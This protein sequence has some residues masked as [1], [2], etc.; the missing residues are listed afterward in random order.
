M[1]Y[2]YD[3]LNKLRSKFIREKK[4]FSSSVSG[5][6]WLSLNFFSNGFSDP[7]CHLGKF[8]EIPLTYNAWFQWFLWELKIYVK[9]ELLCLRDPWSKLQSHLQACYSR[10][11]SPWIVCDYCLWVKKTNDFT[12]QVCLNHL[13][14]CAWSHVVRKYVRIYPW[15][16]VDVGRRYAGRK[17][18]RM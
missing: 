11:N 1:W 9:F 5:D 2:C 16:W 13:H 8:T 12:K 14:W 15:P 3:V 7:P 18:I 17:Y 6:K 10:K 4:E